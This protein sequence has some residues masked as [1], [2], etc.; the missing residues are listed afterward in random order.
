MRNAVEDFG[1]EFRRTTLS[2]AGVSTPQ[3]TLPS[4]EV[5]LKR[6]DGAD[7]VRSPAVGTMVTCSIGVQDTPERGRLPVRNHCQL[8]I[9]RDPLAVEQR[10]VP[11]TSA[12]PVWVRA[13][14]LHGIFER[15][16]HG[17]LELAKHENEDAA[18]K[19]VAPRFH[20]L[21]TGNVVSSRPFGNLVRVVCDEPVVG[22]LDLRKLPHVRPDPR[23]FR[24]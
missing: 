7:R 12:G 13:S 8:Y 16:S 22:C 24:V 2:A 10:N 19:D 6:V 21:D 17:R 5:R 1:G 11:P 20:L 15:R 14:C 18:L 23:P 4:V 3:L 9:E